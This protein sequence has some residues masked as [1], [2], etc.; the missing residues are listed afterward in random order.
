MVVLTRYAW[1]A[2]AT[3]CLWGFPRTFNYDVD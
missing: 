2:S 1:A 3:F